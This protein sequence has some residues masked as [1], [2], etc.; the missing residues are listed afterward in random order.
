MALESLHSVEL[1]FGGR[2]AFTA[3]AILLPLI[4]TYALTSFNAKWSKNVRGKGDPPSVPY[5]VPVVA[6][7]FQFAY[8]TEGFI[9]KTL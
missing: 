6:N 2:L 9:T 5:A 3:A 4:L 8:D 7:T 1:L